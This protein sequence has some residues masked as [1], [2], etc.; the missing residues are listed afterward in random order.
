MAIG[1][2]TIT[3]NFALYKKI[4]EENNVGWCVDPYSATDLAEVMMY[5]LDSKSLSEISDFAVSASSKYSWESESKKLLKMYNN[6][7][8]E[9]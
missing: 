7:L 2:P 4:V 1:L 6:I 8:S 5:I 9:L 3:S